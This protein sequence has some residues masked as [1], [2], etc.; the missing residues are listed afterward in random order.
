MTL[1][2]AQLTILEIAIFILAAFA[3]LIAV[4]FFIESR[5][6]LEEYLPEQKPLSKKPN[7]TFFG[8]LVFITRRF[9]RPKKTSAPFFQNIKVDYEATSTPSE[10][11]DLR[12]MILQ[13]QSQL[14]KAMGQITNLENDRPEKKEDAVLQK[15]VKDY[16]LVI[17][18]KESEIK[19]L[20]QQSDVSK[21]MQLHFDE[22]QKEFAVLQ[23]KLQKVEQQAWE[24]NELAIKLENLQQ[25]HIHLEKDALRKEE[26]LRELAAENQRLHS[27]LNETEDKL[28]EANLQRQQLTTKMQFLEEMNGDMKQIADANRKLQNEVRRIA[29]LESMLN[30][31]TEERDELLKKK[32]K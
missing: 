26:K 8:N 3:F 14:T 1:L 16:E 21:K 2:T 30:L 19:K 10:L 29:E 13:Q 5:K 20:K 27:I 23:Q 15:K 12:T 25:S 31:I 22:M 4:R 32:Y 7:R 24:A 17:E 6:S 11:K 9:R 18:K 28:H